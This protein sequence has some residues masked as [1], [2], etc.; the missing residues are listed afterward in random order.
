MNIYYEKVAF[1]VKFVAF[2][3][4]LALLLGIVGALV[5]ALQYFEVIDNF[6]KQQSLILFGTTGLF[7]LGFLLFIIKNIINKRKNVRFDG[8]VIKLCLNNY[9]EH[10]FDLR[11]IDEIFNYRTKADIAYGLHDGL[12]FRFHKND[13]WETITASLT[14]SKNKQSGITLI[15]DINDAYAK[16]KSKRALAQMSSDQGV[17]FRYLTLGEGEHSQEDY[18]KQLVEYEKTFKD[19]NNTY[20]GFDL[21][22]LVVTTDALYFNKHREASVKKGDYAIIRND[23]KDN[24]QYYASSIVDFYNKEAELLISID[25]SLVV[26]AKLFE[27]LAKAIFTKPE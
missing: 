11:K 23:N 20:G 13:I 12:A 10:E 1:K 22:R 7:V 9:V 18:N 5:Y 17:R 21:D 6:I 3:A 14:D 25:L 24:D 27:E 26:N 2:L 19:Y 4:K 15:K 16:L 8:E